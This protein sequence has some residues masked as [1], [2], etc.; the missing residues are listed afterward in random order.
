M[1]TAQTAQTKTFA[2]NPSRTPGREFLRRN[3]ERH[4]IN[5]YPHFSV[6]Y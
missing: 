1:H 4:Y 3:G 6:H 5:H 2:N